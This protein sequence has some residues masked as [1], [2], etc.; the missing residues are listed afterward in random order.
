MRL[1]RKVIISGREYKVS[2]DPKRGSGWG[3]GNTR[4]RTI[5]IGSRDRG[6]EFETYVHEI[7]EVV[8]LDS[9]FRF[10][11]DGN[12]NDFFYKV[13]HSELDRVT[14]D[15]STALEPMLR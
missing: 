5:Q 14:R 4:N 1:P 9:G 10:E 13:T 15:I 12:P 3:R 8:L 2:R 7:T 6:F 11:R